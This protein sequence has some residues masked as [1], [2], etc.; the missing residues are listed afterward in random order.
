M[1]SIPTYEIKLRSRLGYTC[2]SLL[3]HLHARTRTPQRHSI[4]HT[5]K[6][7]VLGRMA[8]VKRSAPDD[9]VDASG[10]DKSSS[11][12]GDEESESD[13]SNAFTGNEEGHNLEKGDAT[14]AA[15]GADD[16]DGGQEKMQD[17][18]DDVKEEEGGGGG[19]GSQA[20]KRQKVEVGTL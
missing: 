8:G 9:E 11:K 16:A 13:G 17:D 2:T 14:A 1:K 4:Y 3:W 19:A 12:R 15:V 5:V 7:C 6:N 20:S 18:D 10:N